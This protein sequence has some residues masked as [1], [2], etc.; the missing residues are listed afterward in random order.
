VSYL[1]LTDPT[2]QQVAESS[3]AAL[4]FGRDP[5]ASIVVRGEA[6]RVASVRHAELRFEHGAWILADLSSKNGTFLNGKRVSTPTGVKQGDV[7]RLGESGPEYSVATIA[8]HLEATL[9]EHP[10]VTQRAYGVTLLATITGKRFEALGTRIRLGR[11][12]ECEVQPVEANDTIVSRVHAEL[13]VGA[14]GGLLVRDAE[15]KNGTY[16]N[17]ERIMKPMPVRLG[18]KIMLGQGGPVLLRA[19]QSRDHQRERHL[20]RRR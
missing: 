13:T 12:R 2:G 7:I 3:G 4:R 18:D 16:L 10:G 19:R 9:A 20:A 8:A 1:K 14:G 6:A 15:S 5:D 11:G 17:G